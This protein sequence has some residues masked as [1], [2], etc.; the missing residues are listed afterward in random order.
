MGLAQDILGMGKKEVSL[1]VIFHGDKRPEL[2]FTQADKITGRHL[3]YVQNALFPQWH[4]KRKQI[5]KEAEK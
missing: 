4:S 3:R 2:H 5:Q 1:T